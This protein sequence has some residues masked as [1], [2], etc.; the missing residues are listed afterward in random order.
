MSG[1]VCQ[2]LQVQHHRQRQWRSVRALPQADRVPGVRKHRCGERQ[3]PSP[4]LFSDPK[5]SPL[6]YQFP[7]VC[8]TPEHAHLAAEQRSGSIQPLCSHQAAEREGELL[9]SHLEGFIVIQ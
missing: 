4:Q 7:L 6:G 5:F 3:V 8:V 1:V 9:K 2:R